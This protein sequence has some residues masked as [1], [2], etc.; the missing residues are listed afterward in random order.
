MYI[1]LRI[2]ALFS[3][4]S[5]CIQYRRTGMTNLADIRFCTKYR[6]KKREATNFAP[7]FLALPPQPSSIHLSTFS[8]LHGESCDF[9]AH[10]TRTPLFSLSLFFLSPCLFVSLSLSLP[11]V[12]AIIIIIII[13]QRCLCWPEK[14]LSDVFSPSCFS[15]TLF[16]ERMSKRAFPSLDES[17][18]Q[19]QCSISFS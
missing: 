19:Q 15:L 16:L 3:L 18:R 14:S 2:F 12:V 10:W 9:L 7:L 13:M 5:P 17:K 8:S 11:L 1:S 4:L 6:E